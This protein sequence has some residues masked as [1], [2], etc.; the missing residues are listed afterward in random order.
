MFFQNIKIKL[1]ARTWMTLK[2]PVLIFWSLESLQPQWPQQPQQPQWPQWPQQPH[3]IKKFTGPDGLMILCT[4]TTITG[5]FL[6]N[7]LSKIQFFIDFS[8]F[9]VR[10]SWG[11]PMLLFWRLIHE[12]KIFYFLKPLGTI[13]WQNYWFFYPSELIYFAIFTMRHPALDKVWKSKDICIILI[14]EG[15]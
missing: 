9:S 1:N 5:P 15:K 12:L 8:T 2:S 3:F 10:G 11:Q 4:K 13:T 6:W 14:S 7:G